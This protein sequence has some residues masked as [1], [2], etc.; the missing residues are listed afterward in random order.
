M[1]DKYENNVNPPRN[2]KGTENSNSDPVQ[3]VSRDIYNASS[4]NASFRLEKIVT[5]GP[6]E[7]SRSRKT[8]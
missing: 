2:E 1:G 7:S 6:I 5:K 8:L 3:N 4:G